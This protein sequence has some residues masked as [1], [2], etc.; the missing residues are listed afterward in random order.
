[1][2]RWHWN[3]HPFVKFIIIKEFIFGTCSPNMLLTILNNRCQNG[4]SC[5]RSRSSSVVRTKRIIVLTTLEFL[6]WMQLARSWQRSLSI[7]WS[8]LKL[9]IPKINT[10]TMMNLINGDSNVAG[11]IALDHMFERLWFQFNFL[12]DLKGLTAILLRVIFFC[13]VEDMNLISKI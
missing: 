2:C 8:M 13:Y 7:V 10:L 4:V 3:I 5:I 11:T 1:L 9:R 12:F 6:L